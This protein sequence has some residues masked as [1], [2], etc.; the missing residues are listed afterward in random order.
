MTCGVELGRKMQSGAA[1]WLAV[2]GVVIFWLA[3]ASMLAQTSTQAPTAQ[4]AQ[5]IAGTWQGTANVGQSARIVVKISKTDKADVTK[6]GWKAVLYSLDMEDGSQGREATSVALEGQNFRFAIATVEVRYEGK[7]SADGASIAGTLT[8]GGQPIPLNLVRANGETTWAIETTKHMAAD[9]DPAFDVATIKPTDPKNQRSGFH[10]GDGRRV[11]CD[12]E[13]LLDIMQFVYG[14]HSKQILGAPDWAGNEKWDI[15]GYPDAP[16]VAD[17]KQMQAMYR[18][19]IA[20]RFG[21]KM[22]TEKRSLSIYA[23]RVGKGGPKLTKSLD[24]NGLS[25]TTGL[26][27][28]S[29]RRVLRVTATNMEEFAT[30]MESVVDKPVADQTGLTGRWD[31]LLKWRPETAPDTD[32]PN[33]LPGLFTAIQEQIG[34]KLE[35]AKAPV[36]VIVIDH[37][38]RPSAN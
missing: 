10:Y 25:D 7:V 27:W 30:A 21:L 37:V 19:I 38:E 1:G 32:D 28:S 18:K 20:E 11:N 13:T 29:Q 12:N 34:L 24:Q 23:I 26:E 31:F 4:T 14:V 6:G 16:G 15:D 36:D 17:Y 33:A 8:W 9:A 3:G 35:A 2:A 22:H 5:D